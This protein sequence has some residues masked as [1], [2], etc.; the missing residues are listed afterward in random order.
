MRVLQTPS[1]P[2]FFT[3]VDFFPEAQGGFVDVPGVA[4]RKCRLCVPLFDRGELSAA[5]PVLLA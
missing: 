1:E 2:T 4:P 3:L 5:Q